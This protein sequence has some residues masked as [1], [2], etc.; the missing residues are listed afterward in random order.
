MLN[1]VDDLLFLAN[2]IEKKIPA[3]LRNRDLKETFN[4]TVVS[5][6][7]ADCI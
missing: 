2:L 5:L 6:F 4:K 7:T 3:S 1:G